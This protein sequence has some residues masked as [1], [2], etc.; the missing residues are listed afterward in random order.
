M[1]HSTSVPPARTDVINRAIWKFLDSDC[2]RNAELCSP[3]RAALITGR[4]HHSVGFGT[5]SETST[6]YA[7]YDSV[8]TKDKA[9]IGE[10][11]KQNGYAMSWFGKDH[12]TPSF[13]TS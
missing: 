10:I 13:Q 2:F 1:S 12:N 7:G 5:I 8:I 9:T 3:T 6:G 4:N 11:L